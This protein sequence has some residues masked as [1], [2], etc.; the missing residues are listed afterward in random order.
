L[1]NSLAYRKDLPNVLALCQLQPLAL[2]HI[3]LRPDPLIL[4]VESVEKPGNLGA[5]LRTAD[6]AD[7]D[8]VIV[9]DP[10]TDP[11]N[12]NVLRSSVGCFFTR[13]VAAASTTETIAWLR[14]Q[15]IRIFAT[16]LA[17]SQGYHTCDYRQGAAIVMGTEATGLSGAWLQAADARI[18]I[19]MRGQIDSM[20]VS[21]SAAILIYEALRQRG[22]GEENG[23]T[24]GL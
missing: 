16:S 23:E 7:L 20:N 14:A 21:N 1:F 22:F 24:P 17:S 18:K 2:D 4:V 10:Q 19:P 9:C 6:A 12:P 5:M 11:Y 3:F 13:Q 15:G 8:A